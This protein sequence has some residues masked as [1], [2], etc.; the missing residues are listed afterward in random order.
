[1]RRFAWVAVGVVMLLGVSQTLLAQGGHGAGPPRPSTD[2]SIQDFKRA[3]AVQAAPDQISDYQA[4]K[5]NTDDARAQAH[6]LQQTAGAASD[7]TGFYKP[8]SALKDAIDQVENDGQSFVKRFSKAQ[9]GLL[10][11]FI[12]KVSKAQAE[13][14]KESKGLEDQMKRPAMDPKELA[15]TAGRLEKLLADLESQQANLADEMG[16]PK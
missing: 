15:D 1:M 7:G 5:K 16:I 14:A 9:T 6:A 10:K 2:T 8:V 12:K 3:M 13:V 4:L 11:D